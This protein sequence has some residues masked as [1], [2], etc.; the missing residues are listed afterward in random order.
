MYYYY[1]SIGFVHTRVFD[2]L[3]LA[4][5][6]LQCCKMD[7]HVMVCAG[8]VAQCCVASGFGFGFGRRCVCARF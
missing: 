1:Y 7:N 3:L 4:L 8:K 2:D 5:R 6:L